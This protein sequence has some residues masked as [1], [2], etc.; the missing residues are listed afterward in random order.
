MSEQKL[1]TDVAKSIQIPDE[2]FIIGEIGIN[3]NGDLDIAKQLIDVAVEAGCNAVKF[4]KRS[5]DIV[6]TAE[7]LEEPRE[8]PWGTTQRQQKEGLEFGQKEYEII[9]TYCKESNIEWFASAWDIPS[10]NF[11][12]QFNL[13]YNKVAS[14]MLTHPEFLD[15]V[16]AEQ[17][18]TFISTGMSDY[19]DIDRAVEIFRGHDCPFILMHC[20]ST[21]P[22]KDEDLNLLGLVALQKR[23]DCPVAYSGHETGILPPILS[24]MLGA[25]AVERHITLDRAMYGSDQAASLEPRGL[26]Y[27]VRDIRS[28]ARIL[29]NGEKVILEEEKVVASKLRYFENG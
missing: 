9:N 1:D 12:H 11:L 25:V 27:L 10:Q 22:S 16:A 28:V 14:A 2:V 29:G 6:Y 5:I 19:F 4:Q 8:S 20:V 18:Q 21:Y 17:K 7:Y 23:Y 26:Q 13:N 24:V 3:H 15:V